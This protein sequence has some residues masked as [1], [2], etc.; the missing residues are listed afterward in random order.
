MWLRVGETGEWEEFETV[1][2]LVNYLNDLRVGRVVNWVE[3]GF[4]TENYW[5]RD[6]IRAKFSSEDQVFIEQNLE[7]AYL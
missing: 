6:M 7:E 2:E 3:G 4:Q 1:E 5:G